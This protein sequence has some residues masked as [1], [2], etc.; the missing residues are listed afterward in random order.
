[1][2]SAAA[3]TFACGFADACPINAYEAEV[4]LTLAC[5]ATSL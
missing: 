2:T 4:T 5:L 1:M 3:N